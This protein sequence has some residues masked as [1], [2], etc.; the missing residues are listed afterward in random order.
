VDGTLKLCI[1]YTQLNK[2]TIKKKYS[3]W[4]MGDL[5]DQLK[6]ETM[7]IKIDLRLGYHQVCI[8]K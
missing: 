8:K 1:D 2:V 4:R 3:L 6:G 5:F 7:F